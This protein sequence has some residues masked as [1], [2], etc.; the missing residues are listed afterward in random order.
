VERASWQGSH[1]HMTLR[2]LNAGRDA[3]PSLRLL[4]DALRQCPLL[5]LLF[6]PLYVAWWAGP[7]GLLSLFAEGTAA[8]L[9][10]PSPQRLR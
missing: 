10:L 1:L 7:G 2:P 3:Y 9:L 6:L 5:L 4:D 8:S